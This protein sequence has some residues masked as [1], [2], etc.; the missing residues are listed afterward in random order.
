MVG[1]GK[2]EGYDLHFPIANIIMPETDYRRYTPGKGWR[3]DWKAWEESWPSHP[4]PPSAPL[5][6]I[7]EQ[8][9]STDMRILRELSLDTLRTQRDIARHAQVTEPTLT[10][11]LNFLRNEQVVIGYRVRVGSF[12]TGLATVALFRG[13]CNFNVVKQVSAAV[14]ELPFQCTLF[15]EQDGFILYA[16]LSSLD[17]P[18]VYEIFKKHCTSVEMFWCDY[19]SSFRWGFDPEPFQN[20]QWRTDREYMVSN[21]MQGISPL[22]A[23][24]IS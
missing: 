24:R 15:P 21:V 18:D 3:F 10:R 22:L 16:T 7:L 12:L 20:G 4:A 5:P 19:L 9:D 11:R 14:S 1:M 2:I 17:I 13:K 6:S 8:L 23:T